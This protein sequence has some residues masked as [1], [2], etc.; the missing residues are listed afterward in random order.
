MRYR[1]ARVKRWLPQCVVYTIVKLGKT[2][3]VAYFAWQGIADRE[4]TEYP[5]G[6]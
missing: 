3:S 2:D 6:R 1:A 5:A 4:N